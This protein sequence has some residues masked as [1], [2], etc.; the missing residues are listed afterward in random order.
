MFYM[1]QCPGCA[2]KLKK[3]QLED[4]NYWGCTNCAGH[5]VPFA[6][7]RKLIGE[8]TTRNLWLQSG[9]VEAGGRPCPSCAFKLR[10]V[11]HGSDFPVELDVCRTCHIMWMD[12]GELVDFSKLE[13]SRQRAQMNPQQMREYAKSL[14]ELADSRS[15][16]TEAVVSVGNDGPPEIWKWLPA[17]AGLPVELNRPALR[18]YP[19]LTWLIIFIGLAV[20]LMTRN[21]DANLIQFG[22]MSAEPWR[23]SGLTWFTSFFLHADILHLLGNFYFLAVFGDDVEDDISP[24]AFLALL[25]GSHFSGVLFEWLISGSTTVPMVGASAGVFGILAYYML[26]FPHTKVGVLY[27]IFFRP[28]WLRFSAKTLFVFKI[29]WELILIWLLQRGGPS[30][31]IAHAAHFG[32]AL[33]GALAAWQVN[34]LRGDRTF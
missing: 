20:Y 33:A 23:I 34:R 32:G 16:Q 22:F 1:Y 4:K 7:L 14:A 19:L 3:H 8:A 9:H 10:P 18:D 13:E 21:S 26:R 17:I 28:Y 6:T 12:K 15:Y 5:M 30:G 24:P 27:L 25:L 11:I 29:A 2:L 31:G